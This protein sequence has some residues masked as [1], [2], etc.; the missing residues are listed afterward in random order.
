MVND[1][2]HKEREKKLA[3]LKRKFSKLIKDC[4]PYF[5]LKALLEEAENCPD[6]EFD[7]KFTRLELLLQQAVNFT[8]YMNAFASRSKTNTEPKP[9]IV[10]KRKPKGR[11]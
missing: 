5:I 1:K 10:K 2:K 3:P 9:P 6:N 8:M 4:P 7:E 11:H